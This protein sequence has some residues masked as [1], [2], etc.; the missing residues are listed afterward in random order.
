MDEPHS[1]TVR[2]V[3]HDEFAEWLRTGV[4]TFGERI[5]EGRAERFREGLDLAR[6]LGAYDGDELVGTA[7]G[8]EMRMTLPGGAGVPCAGVSLITVA[9]THRRRGLLR[10][11]ITRLFDDA[12]ARG[13]PLSA[14]YASEGGIYGRFGYAPAVPSTDLVLQ[15]GAARLRNDPDRPATGVRLIDRAT[16]AE[17]LPRLFEACV[18]RRPGALSRPSPLWSH[19]RG[20]DTGDHPQRFAVVGPPGAERGYAQYR[21]VPNW[22]DGTPASADGRLTV[23]A[24]IGY[25]ASSER[26]LWRYVLGVDL[27]RTV[28]AAA[29][30][31]DDVVQLDVADRLALA[32]RTGEP[33]WLRL[34]D[35]QAALAA[36]T[37]DCDDSIRLQVDDALIPDNA[38]CWQLDV[39]AGS[40]VVARSAQAPDLRLDVTTLAE[41]YLG[42]TAVRDLVAVGRVVEDTPG[43]AAR[44]DRLVACWPAPWNPLHF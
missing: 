42:H 8:L 34:L 35:V 16:A 21:A 20:P 44:L 2:A 13:D 30:P 39:T 5:P 24:L 9:P 38:A 15:D 37:Y 27:M 40:A 26:E 14:L 22:R 33:V 43:A 11:L 12:I 3:A 4:E 1:V 32:S 10:R 17:L 36:R 18:S 31:V 23:E 25:D 7:A 28:E 6:T 29:R 19:L 41:V